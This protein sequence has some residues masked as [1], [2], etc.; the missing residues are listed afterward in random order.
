MIAIV[1]ATGVLGL[2]KELIISTL[3]NVCRGYFPPEER[4]NARV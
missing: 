3:T 2:R 4:V 1:N